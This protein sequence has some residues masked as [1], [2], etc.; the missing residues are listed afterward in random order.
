[1]PGLGQQ[2]PDGPVG[3]A[4]GEGSRLAGAPLPPDEAARYFTGGVEPLLVV[5]GQGQEV[6]PF[7]RFPVE[8]H[9]DQDDG[10]AVAYGYGRIG[11]LGH[12]ACFNS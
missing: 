11:L 10:L 4:A 9:C 6:H 2:R 3:L 7:P 8:A 5:D 1:M 12:L